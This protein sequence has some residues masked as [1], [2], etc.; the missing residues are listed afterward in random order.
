M[1]TAYYELCF[2]AI[3][4]H[5]QLVFTYRDRQ[6]QVCPH[7]LGLS[8]GREMLLA[9]QFA[10]ETSSGLPPEGEWRCFQ[11]AEMHSIELRHGEWRTGGN[12]R[13][14]SPCVDDVDLDVNP[15]APQ[16]SWARHVRKA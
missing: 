9:F 8:K 12:H 3:L 14:K 5:Q 15:D 4:N 2:D 1:P 6:R 16:R 13:S 10:G 11:L 7:V